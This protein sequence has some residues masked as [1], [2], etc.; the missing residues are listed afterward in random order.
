MGLI[1]D[2]EA[3]VF[4]REHVRKGDLMRAKHRTWDEPRN[5]V[6]VSVADNRLVVQY[7]TGYGNV[8]NHFAMLAGEVNRGEWQAAW[9]S[10][11]EAISRLEVVGYDTGRTDLCQAGR[12]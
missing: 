1:K 11:L 12:E 5:G 4:D 3:P 7:Y 2:R 9:T 10:D 8:T 6:V